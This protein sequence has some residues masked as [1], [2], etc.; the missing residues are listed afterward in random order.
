MTHPDCPFGFRVV[1]RLYETRRLVDAAV[2]Q[3]AI[4]NN[5]T[6]G[7]VVTV[8]QWTAYVKWGSP[9]YNTGADLFSNS[10]GDQTVDALP[11]VPQATWIALSDIA[12]T[13]FFSPYGHF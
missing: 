10:Y 7:S 12:G 6:S 2:D 4:E 11:R 5:R 13:E 9:L 1:G 3:Y 8:P